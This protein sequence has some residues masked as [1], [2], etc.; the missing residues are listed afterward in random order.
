MA[1]EPRA[2]AAGV[3]EGARTAVEAAG[4]AGPEP[5][6]LAHPSSSPIPGFEMLPDEPPHGLVRRFF[7]VQG[8]LIGLAFG[9]LVAHA[10]DGRVL[11]KGR[12][13]RLLFTLERLLAAL[14]R[15]FLNRTIVDR[16]FPVQ[17]RRRLEILGPT[18]IKLGQVLAL[19]Q[20]ILPASITDELKNL[21]DRLPVVDFDR[22]LKLIEKDI[23][24]PVAEMYSWIDPLPLGSASIAQIHRA[25][26]REGDSVILKVVKPGIRETLRRDAILLKLFGRLLEVFLPRYRPRQ[27]ITEFVEYTWR[28]VDLRREADNAETFAANFV[29][30]PGVVFPRIYRQYS[31]QGVLCMEFLKG[32]KPGAPE[33]MGLS[34]EDRDRLVD[35]G[36]ASIIR[37]LFKDGFF[38]ADLHPGNLLILPGPRLGFIDLGMVGRFDSDLRRT[39]LYYYYTLVM[40]DAEGAARYLAL[41]SQPGPGADPVGFR[42]EV[43]EI[44]TRWNRSSSF[45]DFSLAQLIMRSVNLGAQHR[46]YF[47]VEMVLMVKALVTFEGVGQILKPGLDVAAVSRT[48]ANAIFRDQ[49]SPQSLITQA[50]RGAPEVLEALAKAPN[51][52]TEG[53]RLLE[54][55]TRRSPSNPLAGLRGTLFGGFCMVAGAILAGARGPWPVWAIL[56]A[57]GIAAALHRERS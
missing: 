39:F 23:K 26:T 8:H 6:D 24:R 44:L 40:G 3:P 36:A 55:A 25:T 48:H 7:T 32:Y 45:R 4:P 42:R 16:P 19:R 10:R 50:L 2:A 52:I 31:G 34:D 20:D 18:Y 56:F 5:Q 41:I 35:L 28:E 1:A 46:L 15:P 11:G 38:H 43:T 57:V 53:L 47:P 9:A 14:V 27:L 17:L 29:D 12:R 13:F 30:L 54:Q 51:L 22:Y 37:M 49:F 33:T 21:L